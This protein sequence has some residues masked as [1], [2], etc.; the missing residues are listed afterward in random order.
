MARGFLLIEALFGL[1]ILMGFSYFLTH[2]HAMT[3]GMLVEVQHKFSA[4]SKIATIIERQRAFISLEEQGEEVHI[5][6]E[7]DPLVPTYCYQIITVTFPS[8]EQT[9]EVSL[10]TGYYA[11]RHHLVY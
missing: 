10:W 2:W 6:I 7:C 8:R 4:M 11:P 1:M 3:N 9:K 5:Q